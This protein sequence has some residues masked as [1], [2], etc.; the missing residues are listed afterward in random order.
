MNNILK[1][2]ALTA[3]LAGVSA[4]AQNPAA[5]REATCVGG[6]V[7]GATVGG[8]LGNQIGQ[9]SGNAVATAVGAMLGGAVAANQMG[10]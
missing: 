3:G 1:I 9:G 2:V 10:C 5:Q 8:V 7:A 6:T 4:C